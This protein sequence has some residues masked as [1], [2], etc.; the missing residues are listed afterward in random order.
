MKARDVAAAIEAMAPLELAYDWDA[1]GFALGSPDDDV[2]RVFM[3]LN[4]SRHV[5]EQSNAA[6]GDMLIT[7]HPPIFRSLKCLRTDDPHTRLLLDAAQ[8]GVTVYCAHTNL[9]VAPGGVNTVLA[10]RLGL[11]ETRPLLPVD[12]AKQFKLVCFVPESHL[13]AV[14]SAAAE[15]GAGVIGEYTHCTFSSPGVG[16]F[17]PGENTAPFSG[18]KLTLNEEPE[19]RFEVVVP[20]A[21]LGRT[22]ERIVAAHPYEEPAYDV[23]PLHG[24]DPAISLGLRGQFKEAMTLDAAARHVKETL[25]IGHVRVAGDP[26]RSVRSVGVLGGAGG[27]EIAK[28]PGD[29]D[30]FITGDVRYHDALAAGQKGVAVIDAGHEGLE[31]WA[32]AAIGRRLRE[33]F[34]GLKI[35]DIEEPPAFYV[36]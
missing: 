5:L 9:D 30:L 25:A 33:V 27:G 8:R 26:D 2:K 10:E 18:E 19:R 11:V 28:L 1:P 24:G 20:L 36:I 13:D 7:H 16:T 35:A 34:P 31:Q 6:A 22:I 23:Y 32:S 12:H 15:A 29:L 17:V 3:A 14:R 4:F 21:R